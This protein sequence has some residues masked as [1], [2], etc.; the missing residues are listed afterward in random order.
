LLAGGET[1]KYPE[2]PETEPST[3]EKCRREAQTMMQF[4]FR[5]SSHSDDYTVI[6]KFKTEKQAAKACEAIEKLIDNAGRKNCKL[7]IDWDPEDAYVANDGTEVVFNVYTAGSTDPI[8]D[9]M[10][11]NQ[12]EA[13]TLFVD[14][15]NLTIAVA[16]PPHVTAD[17]VALILNH[18]DACAV[19]YLNDHCGKAKK[20]TRANKTVLVWHYRGDGIY[21]EDEDKLYVGDTEIN[22]EEKPQW[23]VEEE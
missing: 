15:Q 10:R 14:M 8:E 21:N 12:V 19:K 20:I 9:V 22:L 7:D 5:P 17:L 13:I 23:T 2:N 16:L 3:S 6:G 18:D 11:K 1:V 4:T